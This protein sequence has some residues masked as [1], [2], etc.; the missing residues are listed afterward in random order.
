[1]HFSIHSLY[2]NMNIWQSWCFHIFMGNIVLGTK[3]CLNKQ[4]QEYDVRH[5]RRSSD[6][7]TLLIHR[8]IGHILIFP[9]C[10][11]AGKYSTFSRTFPRSANQL[12]VST[13][14]AT[15]LTSQLELTHRD[16]LNLIDHWLS[17]I[18]FLFDFPRKK[19]L[20]W[21]SPFHFYNIQCV[22]AGH[23][24]TFTVSRDVTITW[25]PSHV[26]WLYITWPNHELT[27]QEADGCR[28]IESCLNKHTSTSWIL[29]RWHRINGDTEPQVFT[30]RVI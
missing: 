15:L 22:H 19:L 8:P 4:E 9:V 7:F 3:T 6:F 12:F 11:L 10:Y 28:L 25:Q 2:K 24:V 16:S 18:L 21:F 29:M 20:I 1:M 17:A 27:N 14:Q 30:Y 5:S 26:T 13:Q 23:V